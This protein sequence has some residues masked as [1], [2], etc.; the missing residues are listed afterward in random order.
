MRDTK[1]NKLLDKALI[2]LPS[3]KNISTFMEGTALI[4][5][6]NNF[7]FALNH[8]W[9]WLGLRFWGAC[10]LPLTNLLG[11]CASSGCVEGMDPL[12]SEIPGLSVLEKHCCSIDNRA[13]GYYFMHWEGCWMTG[14]CWGCAFFPLQGGNEYSLMLLVSGWWTLVMFGPSNHKHL[15]Q[16]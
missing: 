5:S 14:Q 13:L 12:R 15:A 8:H 11:Q 16:T 1:A 9:G 6:N 10:H 4:K 3:V 2:F 7:R